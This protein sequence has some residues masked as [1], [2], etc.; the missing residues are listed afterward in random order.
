M[1]SSDLSKYVNATVKVESDST[2]SASPYVFSCTLR[3]VYGMNGLHADGSKATGFKSM[4][5]AQFTGIS[6]QKDDNAFII[7]DEETGIY[8]DVLTVS[9][10]KNPLHTNSK[11]IYKPNYENVHMKCSNNAIIQCVSIFAIGYAKHFVA[12]S[13]GDQSITNSNSN[14][15]AISLEANGFRPESFDRDDVGY[16]THIIPPRE[17]APRTTAV[18]WLALDASKIVSA[19]TTY[20]LYLADYNSVDILPPSQIDSYRVGAKRGEELFL[21]VIIGNQES[22]FRSPVLMQVP[23]GISTSAEKTYEVGRNIGINSIS[24]NILTLTSNHQLFNGETVRIYS[25][26]GETPSNITNGKVYYAY[27]SGLNPNQIKLS[28]TLND[29]NAG[30]TITGISNNGGVLTI[31]S[32]VADKI[33]GDVGH[34]LQYDTTEKQWYVTGS[35]FQFYNTIYAGIVGIGTSILGNTT[36]ATFLTRKLDN[37]GLDDRIYKLRYVIPKEFITARPP[38]DGFILQETK[39]VGIGSASFLTS[40]VE[41]V[42]QLRNPKIIVDATYSSGTATLKTEIPHNLKPGDFVKISNIISSNNLTGSSAL[43][44][45]GSFK[46][47]S[48]PTPRTL[49]YTGLSSNPGTFLNQV[50]QRATQQQVNALPTL[51]RDNYDNTIFIYRSQELKKHIP[52]QDGQDGIYNLIAICGSVSPDPTIG[53]G[54]SEKRFNQDIRNLYPQQDR[55]NFNSDPLPTTS[56]AEL[57]PLGKVTTNDRR[58]SLTKEALNLFFD[59]NRVGYAITGVVITGSGNTTVTIYTNQNH[60]LN[61]IKTLTL[62]SAGLGYNNAAGVTST[63]YSAEL[64]NTNISGRSGSVKAV[65]SAANTI[66]S[67][68]IVDPGSAYAIGNTMTISAAPAAAPTSYAVVTVTDITNT[69]GDTLEV[70]G[71]I[72]PLLNGVFRIVDIPSANCV[73]VY[74]PYGIG[75]TYR[76][77]NDADFP[78]MA[79]VSA[80]VKV[81]N[82]NFNKAAGIA[83]VTCSSAHGMLP[84]NSFK[85]VGSGSTYFDYKFFVSEVVGINTFNFTAGITTISQTFNATGVSLH[86]YGFS[87]NGRALGAGEENLGGRGSYIYAGLSTTIVGDITK[88]S[89]SITLTSSGGVRKGDFLIINSEIIRVIGDPVGNVITIN[90]GQFSTVAA[91]AVSGTVVKK[92]RVLPM[93]IRRHSI[94][95]ASGHTFEYLGYGPGNYSTGLPVKQDRVLSDDEVLV[96]QAR[97]QNGGTVV[98]TGMND[99]GEFYSGATKINGATGEETVIEAPVV[100]FFGDDAV[101]EV[102]KRNSGVFDDLVVKERLTVEGGENNNQTSQFYGP[103]NFSQKVT[104]SSEDGLETRDLYIK[105]LASQ[106][107]LITVGISTPA[108]PKKTGDVS[109]IANP[110]PGG[111]IGHVYAD[112]DWRRWGMI[113]QDKNRDYLKLDQVAIGQSGGVYNFSDALEV[114]G[115]IKVKNLYVG[116]AVTFASNQTF[117]GVTYDDITLNNQIL[118]LG[119]GASTYT[120]KHPNA[121][122]IAQFQNMEVTGSAATFTNATVTFQNSFNSTWPGVSTVGGTLFVNELIT[123][124]SSISPTNLQTDQAGINTL[125]VN[126]RAYITAGII[127]NLYTTTFSAA[128]NYSQVG[129]IT[130]ISGIAATVTT[131]SATNVTSQFVRGTTN[132]FSPLLL[133]NT[134]IITNLS[135]TN[136]SYPNIT[137]TAVTITNANVTG[138]L[139]C[140]LA[141]FPVGIIT[142]L[143]ST[144]ITVTNLYANNGVVTTLNGNTG[145][146][147][148]FKAVNDLVAQN[149]L[150]ANVGV[151]T[152]M[153]GTQINLSGIITAANFKSTVG[154]GAAPFIVASSTKVTNL[155]ADLLDDLNTSSS[156]QSSASV[157]ARNAVGGFAAGLVTATQYNGNLQFSIGVSGV[158]AITNNTAFNNSESKTISLNGSSD[159]TAGY[160]VVR[161]SIGGFAAGLITATGFSGPLTGIATGT[162]KASNIYGPANRV[163]YNSAVDTTSTS[164]NLTF[165]GTNLSCAGD[166][167]ALTSDMRLKTNI[168]PIENALEKVCKLSGFTYNW[169]E[170]GINVGFDGDQSQVGVSAQ[171]VQQVVPEAVKPAPFDHEI[172]PESGELK[173]TS[174][175]NYLTVQ[176]EKL[177]P[178]LIESIKELKDE[179]S[180][181][182]AELDELKR[183]K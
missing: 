15:G 94:L 14:F 126:K 98:Y 66:S 181:L 58:K 111:Y 147:N 21:S 178:L 61:Q 145:T 3:S 1:C 170:I 51:K 96:A 110:D 23:S 144:D 107:K 142:S 93:E 46:V 11:S 54:L 166:I 161:N 153:S 62:T 182:R 115:T 65:V 116:G 33:P 162:N 42:T 64:V 92:I 7:Y 109:L 102:T 70:S 47:D 95:R 151:V 136:L 100:S 125:T 39:S 108:D 157:V 141:F 53:F 103:V 127:T 81:S 25:D 43:P 22:T 37:R 28:S 99:R 49:T 79:A 120:I 26:T 87:A 67:I 183:N 75:V 24:S 77:R 137:G 31:L 128:T 158:L 45:N 63:I 164:A 179:I 34:P 174:G 134:G 113:S 176:Y 48:T 149:N 8:N 40:T 18:S 68:T 88:T 78:I 72:D 101:S 106:P 80:G 57:S 150:Y 86:K 74:N 118:Y 55:D 180:D 132:V 12:E 129:I 175:E 112:G 97:E 50:N 85:I 172:D 52:G 10:D 155:N 138:D 163:L 5:T 124:S 76:A 30:N 131:I 29:A 19:G 59:N 160:V 168:K 165:D 130:C 139:A 27:T 135:G 119:I 73:S 35:N 38:T 20:K 4:L 122:S 154:Q 2:S 13:G 171:E 173:S 123:A 114:N 82:I 177:V 6:L 16:I 156:D 104:S 36:G 44:Y 140:P 84:G 146:Y 159:N 41:D 17:P 90:R 9:D 133:G 56:Y 105:G 143:R 71:C 60:N 83:T 89:N 32:S 121:N 148:Y 91:A 117:A 169:N 152:L 69:I 167:T